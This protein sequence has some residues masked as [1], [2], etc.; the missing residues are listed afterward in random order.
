MSQHTPTLDLH[1]EEFKKWP[2][3]KVAVVTAQFNSHITYILRDGAVARLL[4]LGIQNVEQSVVPG[5]VELPV[6][7]QAYL[8]REYD[9]VI[10]FGC[11]IRG[12][13]PHFDYVC[14]SVERGLT[15][16]ALDY[17]KPVIFGVLTCETE[18]QAKARV[19]GSHGH[20]GVEAAEACA[21]MIKE[22]NRVLNNL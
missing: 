17:E 11:V 20:K 19:G 15:R 1:A 22:M 5:A 16:L 7:A 3:L 21:W 13:T 4:E 9:A 6:M 2:N 8:K 18:A 10:A 12:D 14:Q